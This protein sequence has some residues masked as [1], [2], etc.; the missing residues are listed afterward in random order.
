MITTYSDSALTPQAAGLSELKTVL[1]EPALLVGAAIFW[2]AA[3]PFVALSL[4]GVKIWDTLKALGSGATVRPN[5]LILRTGLAKSP[6][7][8]RNSARTARI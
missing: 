1:L 6:L 8:V 4:M 7:T 2:V 3:L 5:P